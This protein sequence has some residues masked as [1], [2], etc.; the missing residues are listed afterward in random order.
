MNIIAKA[1]LGLATACSITACSSGG[2]SEGLAA[3]HAA[4]SVAAI[5][6]DAGCPGVGAVVCLNGGHWDPQ[7]C[8]CVPPADAGCVDN[9]LCIMGDHWDP[10]LCKCAP[11][12]CVSQEDGPCGGFTQN[13][14]SC[15]AG[16]V[17]V[18]NAI[19]DV[20]GTCESQRCCPVRWNMYSCQEENGTAGLNCHNPKLGCASSLTCGGG[21]DFQVTG[22]CPVCDPV[23]CPSG[24]S[25]DTTLCKCVAPG[26]KTAADCTGPLPQ[27]CEVCPEG[28]SGCAHFA[29]VAGQCQIA[30][31][32]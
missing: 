23:V 4:L 21:C 18:P 10:T 17:C 25:F 14:C 15:A 5:G 31:C 29:C 11:N 22:R 20:P 1:V 16:L 32:Q 26:C 9:V 7:T 24:Q 12:A 30:F 27:L 28:G 6:G 19:P 13:P 8:M 2:P 3:E